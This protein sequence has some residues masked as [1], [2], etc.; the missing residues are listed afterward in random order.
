MKKEDK[1]NRKSIIFEIIILVIS[2]TGALFFLF[3]KGLS[4]PFYYFAA[5]VSELYFPWWVFINKSFHSFVIPFRNEFY[6]LGSAPFFA[7][8]DPSVFYPLQWLFHLFFN[9]ESNLTL[10]FYI[11]F[12][13]QLF[14]YILGSVF[15]YLFARLGL[16]LTK[17]ASLISSMA[18]VLGGSFMARLVHPPLQ[19]SLA[20]YPLLFL[21][22]LLFVRQR[23]LVYALI[24]SIVIAIII[25]SGHAQIVYYFLSFFALFE[26]LMV[27]TGE[28]KNRFQLVLVSVFIIIWGFL[29]SSVQLIPAYELTKY[30]ERVSPETTVKNLYNSLHPLY[31]LTLLVPKLFGRHREGYWGSEYPWGNWDNYIYIGIIPVLVLLFSLFWKEK[32]VLFSLY[33]GL[34]FSFFLTIGKYFSLSA[35]INSNMPFSDSLSWVNRMTMPFHFFMTA[36]VGVG[37]DVFNSY[38]LAWKKYL[39]ILLGFLLIGLFLFHSASNSQFV[40]NLQPAGRPPPDLKALGIAVESVKRSTNFFIVSVLLVISFLFLRKKVFLLILMLVFYLDIIPVGQDFNPIEPAYGTPMSM[41]SNTSEIDYLHKD[42]S[43]FRIDGLGPRNV[44]MVQNIQ[45]VGGYSTVTTK[46]YQNI[47]PF[48]NTNYPNILSMA[49]IKYVISDKNISSDRFEKVF[50]PYLWINKKVLPRVFFVNNFKFFYN[51]E[52]MIKEM[53]SPDF[54]PQE[55]VLLKWNETL[56]SLDLTAG[57]SLSSNNTVEIITYSPDSIEVKVDSRQDGFLFFSELQYPGWYATIDGIKEKLLPANRSFYAL[58]IRKG[59]HN[60]NF[61][62]FS[63][64][65]LVG[66]LLSLIAWLITIFIV[67]FKGS[68]KILLKKFLF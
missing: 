12:G 22:Y 17:W 52:D 64:T 67:V 34:I 68:R 20:W 18:Y 48:V 44:G 21:F 39:I 38:K 65:F 7:R 9:A 57:N 11:F 42:N 14:H 43:I 28:R 59:T 54:N 40:S 63:N 16:R 8:G 33:L 61:K 4:N 15:F 53:T 25:M 46:A 49:N 36:L 19:Y 29:L 3:K 66:V 55:N 2:V 56:P 58:P 24:D 26:F 47:I 32:R 6:I 23:K 45:T 1:I 5:D 35:V 13:Q 41:Y 62:F 60:V 37:A 30:S 31:Y 50:P 51:D 27:M 10:A